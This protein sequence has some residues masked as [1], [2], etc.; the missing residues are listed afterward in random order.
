MKVF[1]LAGGFGTRLSEETMLKPKPMVEVG[2]FPILWH[3]MKIYSH[4][5]FNDFVILGG[6]KVE[7]IKN[8]FLNFY[9]TNSDLTI[10][11]SDNNVTILSKSVAPWKVTILDTGL[12]TGTGS[13]I[14]K[15][16]QLIEGTREPFFLT[17]GDG[18]ADVNLKEL[19][20]FHK[21]Q[22]R[23]G[24]VTAIQPSGRFGTLSFSEN[25]S[26]KSFVEKAKG[27]GNWINGGFFVFEPE[28]INYIP[29]HDVMLEQDPLVNLVRDNQLSAYKHY[30]FWKAMDTLRDNK[31]L[32]S[33]WNNNQ[34]S[35]KVWRD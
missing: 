10:D 23:I 3:I 32:N 34:A 11:L 12:D 16:K 2:K 9:M 17:Y 21:S 22:G 15:A 4:Y 14:L 24:T 20:E 13:R 19:L 1:I 31:E 30:G 28:F 29:D 25:N 5:G 18:V 27:D 26:V 6:Y 35:W 7:Y 8:Y 33:M